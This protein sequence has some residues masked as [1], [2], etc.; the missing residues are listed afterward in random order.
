MPALVRTE[1]V[2]SQPANAPIR[3][4]LVEDHAD[5]AMV[6]Q[7]LLRQA[8]YQVDVATSVKEALALAGE[9]KHQAVVSDIGLP[10]GSGLDLMAKLRAR[11]P[12]PG[13]A[14]SGFG[15]KSDVDKSLEAGFAVHLTKP[16]DFPVLLATLS[17]LTGRGDAPARVKNNSHA[18]ER[19][20]AFAA[21]GAAASAG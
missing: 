21:D 19:P 11:G 7:R 20:L 15:M 16:L 6:M 2:E 4:L 1:P 9:H 8:G 14:L 5:T 18:H 12:I 13:I 17:R 10:D 3:L